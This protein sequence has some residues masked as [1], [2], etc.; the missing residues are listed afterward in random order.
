M[1]LINT[2]W[3]DYAICSIL[4][5]NQKYHFTFT[6]QAQIIKNKAYILFQMNT[7]IAYSTKYTGAFIDK[8]SNTK[9]INEHYYTTAEQAHSN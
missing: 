6:L 7:T 9:V 5:S 2:I 4:F 8:Q 3:L 1:C